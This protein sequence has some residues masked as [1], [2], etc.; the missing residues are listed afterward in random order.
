MTMREGLIRVLEKQ[1]DPNVLK[2]S[3]PI[4]EQSDDDA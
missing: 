3:V 4:D 2:S 1:V